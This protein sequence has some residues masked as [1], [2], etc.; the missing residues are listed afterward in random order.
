[1]RYREISHLLNH[2]VS[3][4]TGNKERL[5]PDNGSVTQG[6]GGTPSG[7]DSHLCE[8]FLYALFHS[9]ILQQSNRS[10]SIPRFHSEG[11][12]KMPFIRA[13]LYMDVAL[14]LE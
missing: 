8:Y 12:G 11:N 14:I 7:G 9:L 4:T 3:Q 13:E 6:V 10:N 5:T 1:M 2:A